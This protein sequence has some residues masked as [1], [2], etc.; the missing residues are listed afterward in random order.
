[1][2]LIIDGT[3][4]VER[5]RR[6]G[7]APERNEQESH[8]VRGLSHDTLPLLQALHGQLDGCRRSLQQTPDLVV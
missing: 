8:L 1:M 5:G 3:V 7:D 6:P 4:R 2:R